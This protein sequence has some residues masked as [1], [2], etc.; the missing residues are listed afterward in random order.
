[1]VDGLGGLGVKRWP[2]PLLEPLLTVELGLDIFGS[3]E[4]TEEMDI[5]EERRERLVEERKRRVSCSDIGEGP[6]TG[7]RGKDGGRDG[8][9]FVAEAGNV[10]IAGVRGM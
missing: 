1:M 10:G 5:F 7:G 9:G 3:V 2:C 8:G 6:G 4:R